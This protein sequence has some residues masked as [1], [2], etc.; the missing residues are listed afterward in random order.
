MQRKMMVAMLSGI[1]SIGGILSPQAR[2]NTYQCDNDRLASQYRNC[3]NF[4]QP[5]WAYRTG[6]GADWNGDSRL[7]NAGVTNAYYWDF[8]GVRG[9]NTL[10]LR[11]W[12]AN[13]AFTDT[14]ATYRLQV[15]GEPVGARGFNQNTAPGGWNTIFQSIPIFFSFDQVFFWIEP[16]GAGSRRAGADLVEL[17]TSSTSAASRLD[18]LDEAIVD[19]EACGV[20]P[21]GDVRI[22]AIQQKML[23]AIDHYRDVKGS[24]QISFRNNGQHDDVEFEISEAVPG[25]YVKRSSRSGELSE[26]RSD[27]QVGTRMKLRPSGLAIGGPRHYYNELC[28]P[29]FVHRDDPAG[30]HAASDVALPQNYAFWLSDS[31]ARIAG[32]EPVA[33][34]RAIVIEGH[35]EPYL[36]AKLGASSFRMWVDEATGTLLKL[37][38]SGTNGALVYAI[39][40]K[41]IEFDRGV[42]VARFTDAGGLP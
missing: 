42:D 32:S 4:L 40:V 36:A 39:H 34:R 41:A 3:S 30:A 24:Y 9:G 37:E 23:N 27:G 19:P 20:S 26:Y 25:S 33:G 7:S 18:G 21:I 17:R 1:A 15:E 2:A 12:L 38:G 11:A 10:R 5:G 28:E 29:V 22:E 14:N 13:A 35:H 6:T 16:S 8:F 31:E